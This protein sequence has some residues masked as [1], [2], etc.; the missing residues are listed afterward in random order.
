[1]STTIAL[2][3]VISLCGLGMC[4]PP[5]LGFMLS[6]SAPSSIL[7]H[8]IL[9]PDLVL[10]GAEV[11]KSLHPQVRHRR[12]MLLKMSSNERHG[13]DSA[14]FC[15]NGQ[16]RKA[17]REAS[18]YMKQGFVPGKMDSNQPK[19]SAEDSGLRHRT[20][21]AIRGSRSFRGTITQIPERKTIGTHRGHMPSGAGNVQVLS[22][23]KWGM[24]VEV[25][26]NQEWITVRDSPVLVHASMRY[27]RK[28]VLT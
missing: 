22:Y 17:N 13:R 19:T 3:S 18:V 12:W 11:E 5:P 14:P 1:M 26:F 16:S 8:E 28:S 27:R 20:G 7:W 25:L 2:L 4:I 24:K 21:H 15:L 10:R 9:L 23:V 6:P